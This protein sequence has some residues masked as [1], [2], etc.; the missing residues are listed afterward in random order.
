MKPGAG[1][2]RAPVARGIGCAVAAFACAAGAGVLAASGSGSAGGSVETVRV[3]LPE[4]R[5][6]VRLMDDIYMTGVLTTHQMYVQEPGV[7]AA[8]TWGKQVLQ[9]VK[10]RGWPEARIFDASGRPLNP[11]NRPAAGFETEAA[12][13]FL[14]GGGI[15][16]KETRDALFYA[17]PIRVSDRSC[18]TC[19]VRAK[20]GDVLGGV[21]YRVLLTTPER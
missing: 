16:E 13:A 5:R 9:K 12:S 11:E 19:H 17:T 14:K 20:P 6:M 8:V 3:S 2:W 7:P 15:Q 4:A 1:F 10:S 18:I 21:S